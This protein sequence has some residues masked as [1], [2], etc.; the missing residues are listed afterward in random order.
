MMAADDDSELK[1]SS[2]L[3]R[4]LSSIAAERSREQSGSNNG[5][6][7]C[8]SPQPFLQGMVLNDA[9]HEFVEIV[10]LQQQQ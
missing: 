10:C 1:K 3:H 4:M 8:V 7:G 2:S 5:K 6:S 9:L